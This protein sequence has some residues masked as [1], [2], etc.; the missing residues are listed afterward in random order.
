M[1]RSLRLAI[2]EL[3]QQDYEY[4]SIS[5]DL[6]ASTEQLSA[7]AIQH[8]F[9]WTF[10]VA[11]ESFLQDLIAQ[12]GRSVVTTPNMVHF[13]IQPDGTITEMYQGS[14]SV[15]DLVNEIRVA[16]IR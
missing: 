3:G 13:V 11:G 1:Q 16:S 8:G 2:P 12:Y 6:G 14:P 5:I 15:D 10:A 7:Y 4:V 9:D